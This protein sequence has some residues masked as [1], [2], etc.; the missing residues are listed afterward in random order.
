MEHFLKGFKEPIDDDDYDNELQRRLNIVLPYTALE[1]ADSV[2]KAI[3]AIVGPGYEE[4]PWPWVVGEAMNRKYLD[5]TDRIIWAAFCI[6][7]HI[8]FGLCIAYADKAKMLR[9]E[10]DYV[11][12]MD[13]WCDGFKSRMDTLN[14]L[15]ID[16]DC[17]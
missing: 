6:H 11:D 17:M 5:H 12:L 7:N 3:T 9:N 2:M 13:Y 4:G 14:F 16:P 8:P 1:T 10:G 15:R